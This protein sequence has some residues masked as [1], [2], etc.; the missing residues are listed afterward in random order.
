MYPPPRLSSGW[1]LC[2]PVFPPHPVIL[3]AAS[4]V[5][6]SHPDESCRRAALTAGRPGAPGS[7]RTAMGC[8]VGGQPWQQARRGYTAMGWQSLH[9]ASPIRLNMGIPWKRCLISD[10][11]RANF[12]RGWKKKLNHYGHL[13]KLASF[14]FQR[15][16]GQLK[17]LFLSAI[18]SQGNVEHLFLTGRDMIRLLI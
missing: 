3:T 11:Y 6:I 8:H 17:R 18:T 16:R 7:P 4:L 9:Q 15:H 2:S 10:G 13:I 1:S 12:N 14:F 5:P